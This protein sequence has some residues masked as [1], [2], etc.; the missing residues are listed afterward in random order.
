MSL[1]PRFAWHVGMTG[2]NQAAMLMLAKA[3]AMRLAILYARNSN[4]IATLGADAAD[5]TRPGKPLVWRDRV[6]IIAVYPSSPVEAKV[7]RTNG[8]VT[9]LKAAQIMEATEWIPSSTT[10]VAPLT[11]PPHA[12]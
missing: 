10:R 4:R 3:R 11:T 7:R 6:E 1:P 12:D 5:D 2:P 8:A 9:I